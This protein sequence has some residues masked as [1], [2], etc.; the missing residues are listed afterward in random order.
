[1]SRPLLVGRCKHL[2]L[3]YL[4]VMP[5]G[6]HDWRYRY[7]FEPG[8]EAAIDQFAVLYGDRLTNPKI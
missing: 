3:L 7:R 5:K 4:L 2:R 8:T 1:M 6:A